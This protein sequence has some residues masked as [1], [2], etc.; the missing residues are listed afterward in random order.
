MVQNLHLLHVVEPALPS[1]TALEACL[2]EILTLASSFPSWPAF[3]FRLTGCDGP[4]I[5]PARACSSIRSEVASQGYLQKEGGQPRSRGNVGKREG[6]NGPE[7]WCSIFK[8][9]KMFATEAIKLR[10]REKRGSFQGLKEILRK[11]ECS[12]EP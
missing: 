10:R 5:F 8:P 1:L 12:G 9:Q 11:K 2:Q 4:G 3:G 6:E 7:M